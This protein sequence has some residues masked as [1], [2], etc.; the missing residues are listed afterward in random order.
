MSKTTNK[1]N[2]LGT[3]DK[4]NLYNGVGHFLL[5]DFQLLFFLFDNTRTK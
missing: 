2:F 3:Y 1:V 4:Y 5:P